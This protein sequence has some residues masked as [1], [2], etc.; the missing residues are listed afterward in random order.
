[1][2]APSQLVA[3][4]RFSHSHLTP[5]PLPFR[6]FSSGFSYKI[7]EDDDEIT[8]TI[9]LPGYSAT[10]VD[11][12]LTTKNELGSTERV[13]VVS[14]AK[15]EGG[16]APTSFTIDSK[17]DADTI[18]SSMKNGVLTVAGRKAK[19]EIETVALPIRVEEDEGEKED[20][21]K[22]EEMSP[23]DSDGVA[24]TVDEDEE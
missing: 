18:T 22:A 23:N 20:K 6:R 13:L 21:F 11:L 19:P 12:S 16:F 7:H 5:P 17:V 24:I 8:L 4:L 2:H 15:E 9:S 1:M 14:P 3:S 10:S